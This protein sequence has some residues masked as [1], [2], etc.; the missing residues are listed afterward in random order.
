ML[1]KLCPRSVY[2]VLAGIAFLVAVGG[3]TAWAAA[4]IGAGDIESD[5]VRAR[6]IKTGAV[7]N[8]DLGANSIGSGKVINGSL[9]K[10]DFKAGQLPK[11]DT[12]PRGPGAIS[13]DR[14][15]PLSD[16]KFDEVTTVG[17]FRLFVRCNAGGAN[18]QLTSNIGRKFH[19]WGT[20]AAD[21][22]LSHASPDD[23][24]HT[25]GAAGSNSAEIDVV[26]ASYIEGDTSFK[27]TRFDL[28][29]VRGSVCNVHGMVTPSSSVG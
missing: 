15:F 25:V 21:G 10:Q 11:G 5:A 24:S 28:N 22:V 20:R 27:W 23:Q 1:R 17:G 7:Q 8:P 26:A 19:A 16:D 14:Q 13:I 18:V 4:T 9:R 29:V 3:G 12:G 2:D 6:H